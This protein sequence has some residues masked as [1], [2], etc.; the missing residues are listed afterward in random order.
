M[1]LGMLNIPPIKMVMT[2]EWFI[3]L[4]TSKSYTP[5]HIAHPI[6]QTPRLEPLQAQAL[7]GVR[8]AQQHP[9]EPFMD[10]WTV[11]VL[12]FDHEKVAFSQHQEQN[13]VVFPA[14]MVS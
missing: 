12:E 1:H 8:Q 14:K 11:D 13:D 9:Y 10:G 7:E 2:G 5:F 3:N 4:T 6:S